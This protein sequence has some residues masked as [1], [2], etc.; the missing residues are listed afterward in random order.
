MSDLS[1]AL[2]TA[3]MKYKEALK[4]KQKI[5]NKHLNENHNFNL[6]SYLHT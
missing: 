6:P 1:I 3:P 2:K 4:T 5:K